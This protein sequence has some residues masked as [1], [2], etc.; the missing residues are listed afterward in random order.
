LIALT[1]STQPSADAQRLYDE[2][3]AQLMAGNEQ[4]AYTAFSQAVALDK[5]LAL[6]HYQLGNSQ[7][8][9]GEEAKAE[10]SLQTAIDL[11][12]SLREAYLSLAY[13]YH[14]LGKSD[15]AATCLHTLVTREATD[16]QLHL[17]TAELLV[18]MGCYTKA[19]EIYEASLKQRP[20]SNRIRLKLGQLY[21]K[22]GRFEDA[23][24]AFQA[25]IDTDL[26]CDAAY[27]LL[28]HTRRMQDSDTPLLKRFETLL[29]NPKISEDTC[30]CLH[31]G[32]GKMHDDLGQYDQAFNHFSAAN[33]LQHQHVRFDR[34]AIAEF[35][36]ATKNT[37]TREFF[38]SRPA[39]HADLMPVFIVGMPRSGTTLVERILASHPRIFSLG[40][41]ELVDKLAED[42]AHRLGSP[43][44]TCLGMLDSILAKSLMTACQAQWPAE[45]RTAASVVDK[46][47]LNFLHLG[48]IASL[49]PGARIVHCMRDPLDISLSVYFQYFAHPR[50]TFAYD[51]DDIAYFY[52]Q[53]EALMSHWRAVLPLHIHGLRYEQLIANPEHT[54]RECFAA[55]GL[56]W[57]PNC[58]HHEL[59]AGN[60]STASLWQAR[61][62]IYKHS[63]GRWR[64]YE[65][66][67]KP[68]HAALAAELN[69]YYKT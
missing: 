21:Q 60:I 52:K 7:R 37:F 8:R 41:T 64:N 42:A 3:I 14:G 69:I 46:N 62:P 57:H 54:S 33:T 49:F 36:T 9:R 34:Q 17:Q 27:L 26:N 51:L 20:Q 11:D 24:R 30:K 23:E 44:P 31:F 35:V 59:Y 63:V 10:Q 67:L 68:L 2:G 28:A 47:P 5:S 40:E 1:P 43:Y 45:A 66:H 22:L 4:D 56:E 18:N 16:T 55:L 58:L 32:L 25:V 48:L 65:K 13:L 6:A 12:A 39:I 53:Y 50:I 61:Q 29:G 15:L 38:E 19:A